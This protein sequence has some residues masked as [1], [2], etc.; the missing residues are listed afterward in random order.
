MVDTGFWLR[1]EEGSNHNFLTTPTLLFKYFSLFDC[2]GTL[3][4]IKRINKLRIP[5]YLGVVSTGGG[6]KVQLFRY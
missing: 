1:T 3:P 6:G 4:I 5:F 2:L